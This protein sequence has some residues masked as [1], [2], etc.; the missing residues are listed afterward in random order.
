MLKDLMEEKQLNLNQPLLSMRS[1]SSTLASKTDHK[2]KSDNSLA[3]LPLPPAYKSELNSVPERNVGNVPFVWE[4]AP[5]RPKE[6]SKLQT[7]DFEKP[8]FT[9]N[10]PLGRQ[11]SLA[12]TRTGSTLSNSQSVA[13]LD[14]KATKHSKAETREK[15]SSGSNDGDEAYEDARDSLS[16]TESFFMSCSVSGLSG[17]DEQEHRPKALPHYTQDIDGEESD[18]YSEYENY[19][20][21][22][23][24]LFPRFCLL[25][26]MPGLRMV[27]RVPTNAAHGMQAKSVASHIGS[28]KEVKLLPQYFNLHNGANA[29]PANKSNDNGTEIELQLIHSEDQHIEPSASDF[30]TSPKQVQ[31]APTAAPMYSSLFDESDQVILTPLSDIIH[32]NSVEAEEASFIPSKPSRCELHCFRETEIQ[33]FGVSRHCGLQCLGFDALWGRVFEVSFRALRARVEFKM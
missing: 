22:T 10:F 26:P 24:G 11:Q 2:G 1:F 20:T 33:G 9:S 13:S 14:K 21:T 3:R 8:P 27:D 12:E 15:E 6:E 31:F 25:N 19:T 16:R 18:D 28:S 32:F 29:L 4:K 7:Q 23:C 30:T 17:W 5:G